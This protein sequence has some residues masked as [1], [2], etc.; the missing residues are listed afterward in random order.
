[1]SDQILQD[2]KEYYRT[3]AN[4]YANDPDYPETYKAELAMAEAMDAC[5]KLEDFQS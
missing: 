5:Q 1:M 3:R 2:Y 4:R